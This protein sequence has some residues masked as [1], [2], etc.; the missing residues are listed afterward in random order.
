VLLTDPLTLFFSVQ[1]N[2]DDLSNDVNTIDDCLA[3]AKDCDKLLENSKY[4]TLVI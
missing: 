4:A 3:V 2:H 1:S